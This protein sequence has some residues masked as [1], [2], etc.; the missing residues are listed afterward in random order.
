MCGYRIKRKD[1]GNPTFGQALIRFLSIMVIE[2]FSMGIITFVISIYRKDK[3][4]VHDI[5]SRTY[6]IFPERG[7]ALKHVRFGITVT[8]ISLGFLIFMNALTYSIHD[9][10]I[11]PTKI[12][13]LSKG[14]PLYPAIRINSQYKIEEGITFQ[15]INLMRKEDGENLHICR[16][17]NHAERKKYILQV[18]QSSFTVEYN[19]ITNLTLG[20]KSKLE[21]MFHFIIKS[22]PFLDPPPVIAEKIFHYDDMTYPLLSPVNNIALLLADIIRMIVT[23]VYDDAYAIKGK[24]SFAIIFS[25][26]KDSFMLQNVYVIR[27]RKL[28][29]YVILIKNPDTLSRDIA[30]RIIREL[31]IIEEPVLPVHDFPLCNRV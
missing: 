12:K 26:S 21:Y 8:L 20:K 22:D 6:A 10:F 28:E 31:Q 27:G 24:Q 29:D 14:H 1:G 5:L 11:K 18:S 19:E 9:V 3:A 7:S 2:L 13:I 23:P 16:D 15:G 17:Q 25:L 30:E 4:A